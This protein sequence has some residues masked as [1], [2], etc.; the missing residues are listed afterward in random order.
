MLWIAARLGVDRKLIVLA[1]C[2]CA[3][4]S[5]R[6]VVAGEDRPL[7]AIETARRWAA[8]QAT[9]DDV[10]AAS[11]DASAAA[12]DAAYAAAD[13]AAYAAADAAYAA[14]YAAYVAYASAADAASASS[15]SAADAA[16]ASSAAAADAASAAARS[17]CL[18]ASARLVRKRIP[19][20]VMQSAI[21]A[22]KRKVNPCD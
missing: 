5:L 22:N 1:A 20:S 11:S 4:R 3:E 19:W 10:R 17:K 13:A 16:S 7:V 9:L 14:A 6:F 21:E 18:C 8:G 12:A 2:D 15:A